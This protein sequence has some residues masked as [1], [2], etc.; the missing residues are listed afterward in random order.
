MAVLEVATFQGLGSGT[1]GTICV[2]LLLWEPRAAACASLAWLLKGNH[3]RDDNK[4]NNSGI[5][6]KP[7]PQTWLPKGNH[8]TSR[9]GCADLD[10]Q[11]VDSFL[12]KL[13]RPETLL[14]SWKFFNTL[15]FP[16]PWYN[17]RPCSYS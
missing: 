5:S 14:W 13:M 9:A 16:L 17:F 3:G 11:D 6:R 12:P 15:L 7:L 1:G 8:L 10:P 4:Y 2:P